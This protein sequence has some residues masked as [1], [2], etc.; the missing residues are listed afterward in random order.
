MESKV[1]IS[2][3]VSTLTKSKNFDFEDLK[4][5][6]ELFNK[7][8]DTKNIASSYID[9]L[10]E[11]KNKIQELNCCEEDKQMLR[12]AKS[13]QWRSTANEYR[14]KY[15]QLVELYNDIAKKHSEKT[16]NIIPALEY[17]ITYKHKPLSTKE[18]LELER[19][20]EK[21]D[22][23]FTDKFKRVKVP[24]KLKNK[25]NRA[26]VKESN[27]RGVSQKISHPKT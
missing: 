20:F 16:I 10:K 8:E 19:E 12:T 2:T 9:E 4:H 15:V 1:E 18:T 6:I 22:K 7:H 5:D 27:R 17:S 3:L 21:E 26:Y 24:D 25:I 11:L 23:V 13:K 14:E